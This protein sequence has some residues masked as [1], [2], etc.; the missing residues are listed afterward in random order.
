MITHFKS[1]IL[2]VLLALSLGSAATLPLR[3][4]SAEPFNVYS[5]F[6]PSA[7]AWQMTRQGGL[8]P[9]LYTGTMSWSLP[10]YVYEDPEFR[11]PLS[12]DYSFGGYR[13]SQRSGVAGYG[14]AVNCGGAITREVRGLPDEGVTVQNGLYYRPVK[15]WPETGAAGL[16]PSTDN[17][18]SV[19]RPSMVP[20][21]NNGYISAFQSY[22]PFSDNPVIDNNGS[23]YLYD[24]APD[25]FHFT[26]PGHSGDF[27]FLQDGTAR[28]SGS[29]LPWG[30]V[31]V[32][33][34]HPTSFP[35]DATF[36]MTTGDGYTYTFIPDGVNLTVSSAS[37]GRSLPSK[38]VTGWRLSCIEAPNGRKVEFAYTSLYSKSAAVWYTPK[39]SGS[40]VVNNIQT[41]QF[42]ENWMRGCNC[43]E[44]ERLF[45][46]RRDG[47]TE[48]QP[49]HGAPTASPLCHRL[50]QRRRHRGVLHP[51]LP[52]GRLRS[53]QELP[54]F[55]RQPAHGTLFILL[56]PHA[57]TAP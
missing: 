34:N 36:T 51:R 4:Q 47:V 49:W 19:H 45:L 21:N 48:L 46:F 35:E 20:T 13:P 27:L 32:V 9:S 26:I 24:T 30:E 5:V 16:S 42:S 55:C 40:I 1:L 8:T 57:G 11:I 23:T 7:E 12:L 39:H 18:Y 50:R 28:V 33:M 10:L 53:A 43:M 44:R 56:Q 38:S 41:E 37:A 17:L 25:I 54:E 6:K 22:D 31:S 3:A 2:S 52:A 15:G 29:D 14:W